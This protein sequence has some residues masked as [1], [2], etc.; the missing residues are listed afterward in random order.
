MNDE[1]RKDEGTTED[2]EDLEAPAEA[3]EDVAGG[4]CPGKS[5]TPETG[6]CAGGTCNYTKV[7]CP[8]KTEV[9]IVYRS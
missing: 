2:I 3:Q 1:Q 6:L 8:E 7:V 9:P 5:C 4:K